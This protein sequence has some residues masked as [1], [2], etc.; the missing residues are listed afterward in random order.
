MAAI[1][2]A[3]AGVAF[4]AEPG[5][6]GQNP[7]QAYSDQSLAEVAGRWETLARDERR[8]FFTEMR[9][10]M[11]VNGIQPPISIQAQRRFGRTIRRADGTVVRFETVIQ[12]RI[13]PAA[14]GIDSGADGA[15]K[16]YGTGF[17]HRTVPGEGP[18]TGPVIIVN[19][20]PTSPAPAP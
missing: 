7:F 11:L 12:Y 3:I 17:E 9:R 10:R 19:D 13:N 5:D 6:A 15:D 4:A 18:I 20:R 2:L 16:G 14:N 8:A 1:V